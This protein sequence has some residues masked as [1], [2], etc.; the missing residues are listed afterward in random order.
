MEKYKC[1]ALVKDCRECAFKGHGGTVKVREVKKPSSVGQ[2]KCM[3]FISIV[4]KIKSSPTLQG[5]L[6]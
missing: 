1:P 2:N 4:S 6:L 3:Y 5:V